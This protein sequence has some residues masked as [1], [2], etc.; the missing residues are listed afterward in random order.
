METLVERNEPNAGDGDDDE[1]NEEDGQQL[2]VV[3]K[4][5][6]R[7]EADEG[8]GTEGRGEEGQTDREP[9]HI[10]ATE[11]KVVVVFLFV[12]EKQS[13]AYHKKQVAAA[14]QQIDG[15]DVLHRAIRGASELVGW[16]VLG[17]TKGRRNRSPVVRC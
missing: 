15:M 8:I 9:V 12:R 11:E 17:V 1:G 7:G 4:G 2:V 14:D 16:N 5:A 10:A 3:L 6:L 13:Q